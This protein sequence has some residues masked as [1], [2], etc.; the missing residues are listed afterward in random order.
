MLKITEQTILDMFDNY[1]LSEEQMIN[2]FNDGYISENTMNQLVQMGFIQVTEECEE[3]DDE[4]ESDEEETSKD[5]KLDKEKIKEIVKKL[6]KLGSKEEKDVAADGVGDEAVEEAEVKI[7]VSTADKGV[8][9]STSEG[10]LKGLQKQADEAKPKSVKQSEV[11]KD[12][13][14]VPENKTITKAMV[15]AKLEKF[16]K[17]KK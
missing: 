8:S 2:L 1:E 16:S 7:P 14:D 4:D 15:R 5:S 6:K 10:K 9:D 17:L 13:M 12:N 11:V 3:E